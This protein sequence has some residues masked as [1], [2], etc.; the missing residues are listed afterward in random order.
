[1]TQI[2]L[3]EFTSRK[4]SETYPNVL[5]SNPNDTLPVTVR[6]LEKGDMQLIVSYKGK[7]KCVEHISKSAFNIDKLLRTVGSI[8]FVLGESS[9]IV[10]DS[11]EKYLTCIV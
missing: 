5:V 1:M 6:S 4:T 8:E 7:R 9:S 2:D 3:E 11:I 10:I